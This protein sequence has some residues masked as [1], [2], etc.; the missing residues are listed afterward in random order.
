MRKNQLDK[1]YEDYNDQLGMPGDS[2]VRDEIKKV[3]AKGRQ[4][5]SK[6]SDYE[7]TG[8]IKEN[9]KVCGFCG[10]SDKNFIDAAKYDMHLWKECPVLVTCP[11]CA[12][13][14]EV[15]NFNSHLLN[16]CKYSNKFIQ[17]KSTLTTLTLSFSS[18]SY[19]SLVPKMQRS[20]S[21]TRV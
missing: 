15:E 12:M 7:P 1:L 14:I 19:P 21:R 5:Q 6:P 10:I 13:V 20:C 4:P 8:N 11:Q 3:D 9:S 18:I 17:V 16:E 2:M